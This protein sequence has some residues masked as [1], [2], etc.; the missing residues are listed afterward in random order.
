MVH[1][2][3]YTVCQWYMALVTLCNKLVE[4]AEVVL[5]NLNYDIKLSN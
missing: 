4:I 5:L 3:W 2:T 1:G